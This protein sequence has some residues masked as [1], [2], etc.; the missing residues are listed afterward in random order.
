MV[1][2]GGSNKV[3]KLHMQRKHTW[4]RPCIKSQNR[5]EKFKKKERDYIFLNRF[6]ML[7]NTTV[8]NGYY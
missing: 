4:A 6:K 5:G 2:K 7:T 8:S 1:N 3:W